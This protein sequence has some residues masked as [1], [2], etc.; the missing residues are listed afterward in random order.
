MTFFY[1]YF[2]WLTAS[3]IFHGILSTDSQ[4]LIQRSF[5]N[6]VVAATHLKILNKKNKKLLG[7]TFFSQLFST[8]SSHDFLSWTLI[9]TGG[10]LQLNS[11][12][13]T[14]FR[15]SDSL[16]NNIFSG[17]GSKKHVLRTL[18]KPIKTR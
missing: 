7:N 13:D 5:S 2:P 15:G 3:L 12:F 4:N 11:I 16:N 17:F 14:E 1:I 8:Y 9:P 18:G 10:W 6:F